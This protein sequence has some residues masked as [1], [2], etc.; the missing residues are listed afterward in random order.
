[1]LIKEPEM[2]QTD[3]FCEHTNTMQQNATAVGLRPKQ[4]CRES[5]SEASPDPLAGFKGRFVALRGG[6]REEVER[7]RKGGVVSKP[8]K[9]LAYRRRRRGTLAVRNR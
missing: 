2:L 9:P 8:L 6:N 3:A 7:D 1:M 5:Y 4:Y